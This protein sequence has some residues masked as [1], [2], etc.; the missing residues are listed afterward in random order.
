MHLRTKI[1]NKLIELNNYNSY[2]E[3]GVDDCSNFN[4]VNS[5]KK[6]SVDPNNLRGV[7]TFQM[8]SD[9]FFKVNNQSF[10]LIFIDGLHIFEECYN[11]LIESLKILSNNGTVVLHD[12]FPKKYE[13]QTVPPSD[14]CWT[15]DVWK[16][17]LKAQFNLLNVNI[18]TYDAESGI[19]II[20]KNNN[21]R[22]VDYKLNEIYEY[23][24]F[25]NNFR[26]ILNLIQIDLDV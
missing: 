15:G 16:V 7:P 23:E 3:I 8:T 9:E 5:T 22:V 4:F 6:V 14:P 11:D 12:T 25:K 18:K 13:H 2:L 19:T 24:Y 20:T 1:I 26:E 21:P 17:V 10:D